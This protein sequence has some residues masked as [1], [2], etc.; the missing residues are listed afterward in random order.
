M[1]WRVA[2]VR[3]VIRGCAGEVRGAILV[4][5]AGRVVEFGK[6]IGEMNGLK[7]RLAGWGNG[8]KEGDGRIVELSH[9]RETI[10]HLIR[11]RPRQVR[12]IVFRSRMHIGR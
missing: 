5:E 7:N 1:G 3:E 11:P 10:H 2:Q 4:R 8:G 12:W 9:L 6:R